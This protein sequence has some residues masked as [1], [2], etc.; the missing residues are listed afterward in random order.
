MKKISRYIAS[1]SILSLLMPSCK[2]F[3]EIDPPRTTV[4]TE[5]LFIDSA[6]A[7]SALLGIYSKIGQGSS[8]FGI[9]PNI[10]TGYATFYGGMSSDELVNFTTNDVAIQ[11]NTLTQDNGSV[12]SMWTQAYSYI[13]QANVCIEGLQA[14]TT[15]PDRVKSKFI[16]EARFLRAYFYFYLVNFFGDVPYV[17]SGDWTQTF[18]TGRTPGATVYNNMVQDLLIA[19][20]QLPDAYPTAGRIRPV[21]MAATALLARIYL[22]RG[23][24]I[25]AR[26]AANTVITSGKYGATLPALNDAFLIGSTEAIWQMQT[27]LT[28][29]NTFE[30]AQFVPAGPT[31]KSTYFMNPLLVSAFEPGDQRRTSWVIATRVPD[32]L[33]GDTITRYCPYKYKLRSATTPVKEYLVMLRLGE[34]YLIRAEARMNSGDVPGAVRDLNV[35][36]ARAGLGALDESMTPDQCK[37]AVEQ[38][39]RIELFAEW[40]HRWFDLKRTGRAD[41]VMKAAKPDTWK[42]TAVLYPIPLS[43]RK[44]DPSLSPQNDGYGN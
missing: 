9:L 6:S 15:I 13:Y 20:D 8:I 32:V 30:G 14:S 33:P 22:Y 36:R 19:Q 41:V 31:S 28:T 18:G 34:Q 40:G 38:E 27:V 16:A 5:V 42:S 25:K 1:L 37:I 10:F 21:K 3:V 7:S 44:V 39:R 2:K 24:W 26:D 43:E 29:L 35:I 17:T 23:E 12:S 11:Q 4:S